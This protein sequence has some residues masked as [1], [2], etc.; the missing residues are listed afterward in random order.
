[1]ASKIIRKLVA[2]GGYATAMA[3]VVVTS[4]PGAMAQN[5]RWAKRGAVADTIELSVDEARAIPIFGSVV[6]VFVANP[7]IAD[8][9]ASDSTRVVVY[10]RKR[11]ETTILMNE[12]ERNSSPRIG[13]LASPGTSST[14]R[15]CRSL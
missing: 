8:V 15:P 4:A 1:M 13:I 14:D 5:Q 2:V 9:E 12:R 11:G 10:G 3:L 7:E 6:K